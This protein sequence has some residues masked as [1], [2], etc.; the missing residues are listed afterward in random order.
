[1]FIMTLPREVGQL[2]NRDFTGSDMES[3]C[4]FNISSTR[5]YLQFKNRW[6]YSVWNVINL[7][8]LQLHQP[9]GADLTDSVIWQCARLLDLIEGLTGRGLPVILAVKLQMKFTVR[10]ENGSNNKLNKITASRE[11]KKI[12]KHSACTFD[13]ESGIESI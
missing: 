11:N 3:V 12:E 9:G 2:D 6:Q 7:R 10:R 13:H 1:M 5:G 8:A 4:S